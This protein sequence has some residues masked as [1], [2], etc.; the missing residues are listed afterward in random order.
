[1]KKLLFVLCSLVMGCRPSM[2]ADPQPGSLYSVLGDE[3]SF[4]VVKVLVV[5]DKGIHIRLYKQKFPRRPESVEEGNLTLGGIHD[6]DGFGMGHL[7][8]SRK[9]FWRMEPQLIQMSEVKEDELDGYK[10]W[11][12]AGGGVFP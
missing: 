12:K 11:K 10:E 7:P 4:S 6:P 5:D 1:M 8:L 9:A 2:P 3:S